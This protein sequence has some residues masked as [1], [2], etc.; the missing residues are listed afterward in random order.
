MSQ[1][2]LIIE[3]NATNLYLME[4]LL[5]SFGYAVLTAI[6]GDAGLEIAARQP[7]DLI[8]CDIQM[9]GMDG[10][11][12]LRFIRENPE[13][14]DVQVVAITAFAMAGDRQKILASGFDNYL[15]KPIDPQKFAG[16]IEGFL[17]GK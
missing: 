6:D 7:L 4:Y 15:P 12:V 13:M 14:D 3:D 1:R 17:S 16:Q 11:E 10:Y 2:I 5:K 9:P 8:I